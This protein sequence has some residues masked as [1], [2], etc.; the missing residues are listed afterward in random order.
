MNARSSAV[1]RR[2]PRTLKPSLPDSIGEPGIRRRILE[3][4]LHLFARHGFHGASVRDLTQALEL[5]PSQLYVH[6]PSKEHLLAELVNAGHQTLL[7]AFH[8]ALLESGSDPREQLA[9]LA[10]AHAAIHLK[11]PQLAV[12]VNEE[13]D[14]LPPAL[15]SVSVALR[16]EGTSLLVEVVERGIAQ[17]LF[18]VPDLAVTVA[19]IAAMGMRL[20]YWHQPGKD[21]SVEQLAQTHGVLAL[22]LVGAA[23]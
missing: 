19:A 21:E 14:L 16:A 11:H 20:P 8:T 12:V 15:I 13:M 22:R 2:I 1:K 4:A 17:K 9:A 3:V 10:R 5:Q 7:K 18:S 23:S 6:F